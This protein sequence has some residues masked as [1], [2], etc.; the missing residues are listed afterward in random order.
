MDFENLLSR[1]AVSLGMGLLIGLERGWR[2]RE[3]ERGQRAAGIRT[4]A[5]SGLLGGITGAIALSLDN[6]TAIA[7]GLVLASGFAAHAL[8]IAAFCREENRALGT[9]S[10]TT[11]VAAM[12][13]FALGAYALVGDLR[14]AAAGAVAAAAILALREEL[15]GWVE[16]ITWPELRSGLVLLAMSFIA[17]P[18]MPAEPIGP[19]GG[20]NPR[21]VWLIAIVLACVSFI[22]YAAVKY[23]GASRGVL[24]AA[25]AGGLVSS[26]AVTVANARRAAAGEGSARLLAAG[27]AVATAVMFLRVFVIAAALQPRLLL[28]I[29]APL[30]A[31]ALTAVGY[32]L[33]TTF[34]L[35]AD[36]HDRK[37]VKFRNPFGFWSV[38]GVAVLLALVIVLGRAVGESFGAQ[39]AIVGAIVVGLVDVDSVTV[40][41]S[42]LTPDTLTAVQ[43]S[44][45]ILAAVASDTVSKIGIGALL[46]RG[47]FAV[48]IAVMAFFCLTI[49]TVVLALLLAF[50]IPW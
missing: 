36:E 32:A 27:V 14:V 21:E 28:L 4:F 25:A 18:I 1:V 29:G 6:A 13:T 31:G 40:A 11:V 23:L 44:Y 19:F 22:G 41:M 38:V 33:V 15:H 34:G 37:T 7:G 9:Y 16:T 17:L 26:T 5:V 2:R 50:P 49:A 45:A 48:E 43:A 35:T 20:V 8:V 10:A 12:L 3:A 24:L 42:R 39:G 47:W 46:G 30:I